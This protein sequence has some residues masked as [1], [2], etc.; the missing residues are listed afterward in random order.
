MTS[1]TNVMA[2]VM[3]ALALGAGA[4]AECPLDH[5]IIG[6]NQD[7][8]VGTED[9]TTLF[10]DCSQKYRNSGDAEYGNWFYPLRESIFSS[11]RYRIGEPGFDVFQADDPHAGYTYDPNR[12]VLGSPEVDY[13]LIVECLDLSLGLRAVHKDYPQ[14]TIA[15]SGES[16]N[17]ST[18][19][20][21]RNDGHIHM[22]Y[23]ADSGEELRWI[24]FCVYDALDD[25]LY[26]PSRPVTIVFNVEPL[27]GD[28]V[29]D[30][31]VSMDDLARFSDYWVAPDSSI[32][33]DY[34]ER[35][36][37]NRDGFVD[38]VDFAHLAANWRVCLS[39][40]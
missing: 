31:K 18:I 6:C 16:F 30:G 21:L 33:N 35:A 8:I 15:T 20:N 2:A 17:H 7:R 24:T 22:S 38:F 14:F 40:E 10:M 28:L 29:V 4:A 5:F 34:C 26:Q 9:D 25:N 1:R 27:R 19:V 32:G 13:S 23:Q 36:D 11:Y 3:V 39:S 37:T 12:A